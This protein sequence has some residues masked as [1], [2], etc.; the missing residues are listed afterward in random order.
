M[1]LTEL[2]RHRL[3]QSEWLLRAGVRLTDDHRVFTGEDGSSAYPSS[4]TRSFRLFGMGFRKY[5]SMTSATATLRICW[6][7]VSI[8]KLR[9]NG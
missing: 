6:Q 1:L 8:Q 2:R 7:P 3:Q 4:L 5:A 9:K